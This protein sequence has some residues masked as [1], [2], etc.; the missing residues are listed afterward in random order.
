MVPSWIRLHCALTETPCP[1]LLS[2]ASWPG[3]F[4]GNTEGSEI[5]TALQ[6]LPK[7]ARLGTPLPEESLALIDHPALLGPMTY[8]DLLEHLSSWPPLLKSWNSPARSPHQ[9]V[10]T[11]KV[12]GP[13]EVSLSGSC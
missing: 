4:R 12:L 10:R 9:Q 6:V 1:S 5:V 2:R 13:A 7:M 8:L 3:F 11:R